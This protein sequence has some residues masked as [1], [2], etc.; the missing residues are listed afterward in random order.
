MSVHRLARLIVGLLVAMI[1]AALASTTTAGA[2]TFSYD[3]PAVTRVDTPEFGPA[4]ASTALRSQPREWAVRGDV[5]SRGASTTSFVSVVATEAAPF[6]EIG[7]AGNPGSLRTVI[8]KEADLG[9]GAIG[10]GERTL[11]DRLPNQGSPRANWAQN[12]GVL[13]QEMGRGMP[14][15][16]ASVNPVTGALET[17]TGF[18]RAERNLLDSRGWTYDPKTTMWYP[19][20]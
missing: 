12:D 4:D 20:G 6:G 16:D 19:P 13:R 14:I 11:L 17:N 7:P 15:R 8:G 2:A 3:V 9:E 5:E 1:V 10:S 18:L